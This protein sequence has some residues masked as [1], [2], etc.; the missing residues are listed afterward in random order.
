MLRCLA[1]R[2][3]CQYFNSHI[4]AG[5]KVELVEWQVL[6]TVVGITGFPPTNEPAADDCPN[7]A[8]LCYILDA[9]WLLS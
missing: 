5:V 8:Y 4:C 3:C 7:V 9:I 2:Y 6:C 1:A